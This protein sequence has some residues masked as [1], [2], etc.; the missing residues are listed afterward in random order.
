[1][2]RYYCQALLFSE[3]KFF[4]LTPA[5][6]GRYQQTAEVAIRWHGLLGYTARANAEA[7]GGEAS[8]RLNAMPVVDN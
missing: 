6:S 3:S 4:R 7:A 8:N 1:M 5:F 2:A